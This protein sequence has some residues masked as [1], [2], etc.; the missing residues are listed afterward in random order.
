MVQLSSAHGWGPE[1]NGLGAGLSAAQSKAAGEAHGWLVGHEWGAQWAPRRAQKQVGLSSSQRRHCL[2][3]GVC[4]LVLYPHAHHPCVRLVTS[5]CSCGLASVPPQ[6][7]WHSSAHI[8]G[9]PWS[10]T[11][12]ASCAAARPAAAAFTTMCTW[13]TGNPERLLVSALKIWYRTWLQMG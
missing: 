3:P 9:K 2:C 4:F 13:K 5:R 7:Y 8:L 6:V 1:G 10:S 12:G 11:T